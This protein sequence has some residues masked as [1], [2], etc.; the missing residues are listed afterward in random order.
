MAMQYIGSG[1][2]LDDSSPTIL[3]EFK[4]TRE[5][6]GVVR[7]S[8]THKQ[9]KPHT[10]VNYNIV[11]YNRLRAY[12]VAPNSPTALSQELADNLS[13]YTPNEVS[14]KVS[15]AGAALRR[16][17]DAGL[18]K[19]VGYEMAIAY[20]RTEEQEGASQFSSFS[21]VVGSAGTAASPGALHAMATRLGYGNDRATPEAPPKPWY[22]V[23]HPIHQAVVA[24]RLVPFT[25]VPVGTNVYTGAANG[26]TVGPGRTQFGD[27]II[28]RGVGAL[29]ML[30][31]A[32]F[33]TTPYIPVDSSDDCSGALFSQD[34]FLYISEVAYKVDPKNLERDGKEWVG[35]GAYAF[36]LYKLASYGVEGLFD[37]TQLT[38]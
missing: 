35:W 38:A 26:V 2:A 28:K 3:S 27:E 15:V 8:A 18:A 4:A 11:N 12:V 37:A 17:A 14:V 20:D 23:M 31:G 6:L 33:K 10:G 30:N 7:N 1:Q 24:G 19:E 21:S 25:D 32:M 13:T 29:G 36:G 22:Y 9:M 16:S 34:G 5:D